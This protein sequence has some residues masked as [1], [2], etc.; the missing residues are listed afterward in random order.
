M[1]IGLVR[2]RRYARQT[3]TMAF[4]TFCEGLLNQGQFIT[5]A[6][7]LVATWLLI[8]VGGR[9]EMA[10]Q[11]TSWSASTLAFIYVAAVWAIYSLITAPVRVMRAENGRG[12]WVKHH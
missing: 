2:L 5:L 8:K 6:L 12:K 3:P 11:A 1:H 4:K 10:A 7:A 9:A